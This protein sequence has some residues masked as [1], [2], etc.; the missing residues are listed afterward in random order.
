MY[1]LAAGAGSTKYSLPYVAGTI[2]PFYSNASGGSQG[3]QIAPTFTPI[4]TG[5]N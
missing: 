2:P 1:S 3:S 5:P 4:P